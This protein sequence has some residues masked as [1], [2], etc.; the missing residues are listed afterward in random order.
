V[1]R[2][3]GL[4]QTPDD[5]TY[6]GFWDVARGSAHRRAGDPDNAR[7]GLERGI[8]AELADHPNNG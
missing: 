3:L 7:A 2:D 8:W 6:R 4:E 5:P 1:R